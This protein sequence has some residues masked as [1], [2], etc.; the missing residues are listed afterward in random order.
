VTHDELVEIGRR[1]LLRPWRNAA[2]EGHS[3]CAVVLTEL[4][5]WNY[6]GE[7]PDVL[8][9]D[10]SKGRSILIECKTSVSD[11]RADAAKPFRRVPEEGIGTF[12]FFLAPAGLLPVDR[13]PAGWGFLEV[14]DMG[15]VT[16]A[17]ASEEFPCRRDAE[18]ALLVSV[19][20]RLEVKEGPHIAIRAYTKSLSDG[21][22]ASVSIDVGTEEMS[23][24]E[25]S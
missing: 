12:R 25:E 13:L 14:G 9:W 20:R 18:V 21:L 24:G 2:R 15:R 6:T 7:I 1:W 19:M 11:F 3:A 16:V 23:A 4:N 8:G 5:T 17:R 22:R 10:V